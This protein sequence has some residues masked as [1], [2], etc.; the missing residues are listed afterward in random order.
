MD[1]CVLRCTR[2]LTHPPILLLLNQSDTTIVATLT[3]PISS[4]FKS[5]SLLSWL[6]SA[7]LI[8]NAA[9]Q[10][11]AG[12]LTDIFSRR[13]G[14]I[15][16]NIFFAAGCLICGLAKNEFVIIAGRI[17][18]G[19]GGGG[20]TAI[21]TFVSS[22]L[23]PLRRRGLWQGFGNIVFGLGQSLG[24]VVGGW[25]NDTL[26]WRS[27]FL[28]QVP[29]V[30]VSGLLVT[31]LIKIPVKETKETAWKRVDYR[32]AALLTLSLV[33]LLFG[34]NTGGNQVPWTHP[35]VLTVLPMSI[36][37]LFLFV[38]VEDGVAA[39]PIIPPRLMLYRTVWAA[40]FANFFCTMS[41]FI[42]LFYVPFYLQ[43]NG[44]SA[45]QA[46]LRLIPQAF[47]VSLGS[48]G[49]GL[50]MR[51][52]GR[53]YVMCSIIMAVFVI[54]GALICTLNFSSPEWQT[55]VYV[56]P[57]G[58][59]YGGMLT[60]TL[61]ALIAAVDHKDQA[62]ITSASYAF[63]STGSTIGIT[64]GSAVFQNYLSRSL[65]QAIENV[66]HKAEIVRRIRDDY[67]EIA[68]LPSRLLRE[69]ALDCYM[70]AFRATFL[71]TLGIAVLAGLTSLFMKEHK[72]HTNLAR[73]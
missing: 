48:L 58:F 49:T 19:I 50:I 27:A 21:S 22:D 17:V 6:A 10:P 32:G 29:F 28:I 33:L 55:F 56:I 47:A 11:V 51:T 31:F 59:G 63:R 45:T 39:E 44:H 30:V 66:H 71:T 65:V 36:V 72:L 14:L 18:S 16:S 2:Y 35:L 12:K 62:V 5:L 3:T 42:I 41:L 4:E 70:G 61:V 52:T 20:L 37:F 53:Y 26:G 9:C 43:V 67:H 54:G 23:V 8:A 40:C 13:N 57:G 64:I 15:F 68:Q 69:K 1:G 24:G 25:L 73:K 38:Y 46:G 60:I 7:Y 34:L